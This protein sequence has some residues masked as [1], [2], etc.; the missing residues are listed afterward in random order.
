MPQ[1]GHDLVS[2]QCLNQ[3]QSSAIN[4]STRTYSRKLSMSQLGHY[5]ELSTPQLGDALVNYQF[6]NQDMI[7]NLKQN[8]KRLLSC[9]KQCG[10]S[11]STNYISSVLDL[12]W[13]LKGV[14]AKNKW[15]VQA[16]CNKK[17]LLIATNLTSIC[18]V[19]KEKI[20]KDV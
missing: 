19:Y 1:L 7:L 14:F 9:S 12:N 16:L 20:V 18:C 8:R 5:L 2:Y 17:A 6:L 10:V 3:E 11:V 13:V 15:G 4:A